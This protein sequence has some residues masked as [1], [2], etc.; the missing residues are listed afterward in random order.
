MQLDDHRQHG[1][2]RRTNESKGFPLDA[3]SD[4]GWSIFDRGVAYPIAVMFDSI[5]EH[6]SDV[7][8]AYCKRNDVSLAPH[9]KTTMAPVLFDRQIRD[10]SWAI[11]AATAW[12]AKAMVDAGVK[13]VFLANQVVQ[14]GEI[15]WISRANDRGAEIYT[16]IDSLDGVEIMNETLAAL[17]NG[18]TPPKRA[19]PV[20]VEMGIEDGR[21]GV[22]TVE[23]GMVVAEA[24]FTSPHLALTGVSGFDGILGARGDRSAF[25]VVDGF[26]TDI[27]DL[28]QAIDAK[29]WFEPTPEVVITAGGSAY[30]D[31]VVAAFAGIDLSQ[32]TRRVIRSGCYITHDDGSYHKSSPMGLEPRTERDEHLLPAVEIWASVL[33]RPEPGL[34]L[35]GLGKRDASG[36]GLLPL[37]KKV[38]R[39]GSDV[40]EV[41]ADQQRV[42]E[43]NDQHSFIEIDPA[44]TLAV[45]DLIGFGISHP[46]TTF[47][48][49]RVIPIVDDAYKV[50]E[51]AHTLF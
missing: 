12:Q 33:S 6:N 43:F 16:Y 8:M 4:I 44:S 3:Q 49:W 2:D 47:D 20:V 9:G 39:R 50:T 15:E 35:V 13:R 11:T 22:R 17:A 41:I 21:T 40:V 10:G 28:A 1:D 5:L 48:K 31:R 34:V 27:V 19:L 25:E 18:S 32:P 46:C 51:V 14:P 29:G 37:M 30:F 36:D 26:L 24:A 42:R 23:S 38:R 7:M 45:G